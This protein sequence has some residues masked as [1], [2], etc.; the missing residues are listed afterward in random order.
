MWCETCLFR[1][2]RAKIY[3]GF[4]FCGI[5]GFLRR[6]SVQELMTFADLSCDDLE[7]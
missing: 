3:D 6:Y 5:A 4:F 7:I 1:D 2:R